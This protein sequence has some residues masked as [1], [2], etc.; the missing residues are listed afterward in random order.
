MTGTEAPA[1]GTRRVLLTGSHPLARG[2][3]AGL[4]A[5]GDLVAVLDPDPTGV[6][7]LGIV[8]R[9]ASE[10][11]VAACVVRATDVLGG[12][13]QVVHAWVAPGLTDERELMDV[14]EASWIATCE[15][16]FEGAWWLM[17]HLL[18]PM[19]ASGGRSVVV[20]VPSIALAGAAGYAM[21]ATVAE[22]LRV[23]T[24]G[25]GRQW[26]QHGITANTIATAPHHWVSEDAGQKLAKAISLS[27]PAFGGTGDASDDLAPLVAALATPDAHFFTA[28][29]LVADGGVWMGL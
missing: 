19:R 5:R 3:A 2:I 24:K 1:P 9:F 15:G 22:G 11:E 7:A 6:D 28:G 10:D 25:C 17:R 27:V 13:D 12:I 21:L 16:S 18:A 20:L 26:A 29:T 23:L 14:D 4:R 8:C